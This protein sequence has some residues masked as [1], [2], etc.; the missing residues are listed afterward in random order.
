MAW[1]PRRDRQDHPDPAERD[2]APAAAPR[3]TSGAPAPA[4]EGLGGDLA[5]LL[6][7]E[8]HLQQVAKGHAQFNGMTEIF[9]DPQA[10]DILSIARAWLVRRY[11]EDPTWAAA[12][13]TLAA[14]EQDK[15]D[16]DQQIA[17]L[18]G[19]LAAPDPVFTPGRTDGDRELGRLAAEQAR[20]RC[21]AALQAAEQ[22]A[23]HFAAEVEAAQRRQQEDRERAMAGLLVPAEEAV[24]RIELYR[25]FLNAHR[26]GLG[27]GPLPPPPHELAHDLVRHAVRQFRARH[28]EDRDDT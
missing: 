3:T 25:G 2:A 17:R 1:F 24:A 13:E 8:E 15:L 7:S 14:A 21:E 12:R 26:A 9:H 5:S 18:R 6:P 19:E 16:G 23:R 28:T 22:K 10:Q 27:R 11:R 20:W 4:W